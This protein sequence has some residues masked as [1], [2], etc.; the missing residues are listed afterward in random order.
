MGGWYPQGSG[1]RSCRVGLNNQ[2]VADL[3]GRGRCGL[4]MH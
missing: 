2:S 4:V 3:L 1:E